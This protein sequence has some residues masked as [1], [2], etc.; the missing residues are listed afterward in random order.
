MVRDS[1][2]L[3]VATVSHVPQALVTINSA[4]RQA[5]S[6]G[7]QLFVVDATA[8]AIEK[9]P[10]ILGESG[11]G[12]EFFGPCDL[13][14]EQ[15]TFLSAFKYYNAV[16]MSCLAKYVGLAHVLR[17]HSADTYVYADAD[18]LVLQDFRDAVSEIGDGL[19]LA[20]PHQLGSS[21]DDKEHEFLLYGWLNAG[22]FCIRPDPRIHEVLGWLIH[23]VSRRGFYAPHYGMS[24]DQ[25]WFSSLPFVFPDVTRISRHPGLNVG[26]WNLGQRQ[27]TRADGKF[28]VN[29]RP[30]LAFHFS[31]F[32]PAEP[33]MLSKYFDLEVR[34]G[35]PLADLC[36]IYRDELEAI[37]PLKAKLVELTTLPCSQAN[38]SDRMLKGAVQNELSFVTPSIKS[39]LFSR[40]GRRADFLLSRVM[41]RLNSRK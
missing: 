2:F 24:G 37:S 25:K 8:D 39:G 9:L 33:S 5:P 11:S 18:I 41:A 20:T 4:R 31:G 36:K 6:A 28:C 15:D 32:D 40:V 23:R 22:F 13:G 27:L 38:L 21:S 12:V 17:T 16:E 34:S 26:Y 30:L 7:Y 35:S 14:P 3:T 29:G 10:G 1:E 19:V